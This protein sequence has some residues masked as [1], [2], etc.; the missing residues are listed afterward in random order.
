MEKFNE[1][2]EKL[3]G[4]KI[5]QKSMDWA[6]CLPEEIWNEHFKG[7]FIQIKSGLDPDTHRWYETS[8]SVI[9]IYDKLLGI[10]HISNLFSESSSCEDCFVTIDFFEMKEVQIIS[11][12]RVD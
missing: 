11:Y 6:E 1:L 9:S 10:T 3:N 5:I 12:K 8:I 7:N 2:L 4:L